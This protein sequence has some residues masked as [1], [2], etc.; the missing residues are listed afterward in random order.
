MGR[1]KLALVAACGAVVAIAVA[2]GGAASASRDTG[3][4]LAAAEAQLK[5]YEALPTFKAPGPPIDARAIMKGKTILSIPVLSS[6]PFTTDFE[7]SIAD[8]AKKIGFK[9]IR[10][11]NTG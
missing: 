4:N 10:W 6:N 3:P 5:P 1:T 11:N 9:F 2:A 7:A 8:M